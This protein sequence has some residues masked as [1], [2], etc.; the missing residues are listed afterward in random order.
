M[1]A[2][3]RGLR[4]EVLVVLGTRD[5]LVRDAGP[6]VAALRAAGAPLRVETVVGGGHAVNEERPAEVVA[7]A[8]EALGTGPSPRGHHGAT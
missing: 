8:L 7:L 3:M 2:R 1:A 5:R 6:Y 4:G